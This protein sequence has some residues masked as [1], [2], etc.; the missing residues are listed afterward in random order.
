[1][2]HSTTEFRAR[3]EG[4]HPNLAE[5]FLDLIFVVDDLH[6]GR[7]VRYALEALQNAPNGSLEIVQ[8]QAKTDYRTDFGIPHDGSLWI[9]QVQP[10]EL[11]ATAR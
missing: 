9:V 6:V 1:M 10:N 8:V 3:S 4:L 11:A 2:S 5:Q 7:N